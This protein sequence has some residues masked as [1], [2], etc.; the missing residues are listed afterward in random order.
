MQVK[1]ELLKE[2]VNIKECGAAERPLLIHLWNVSHH[3]KT[4]FS[5]FFWLNLQNTTKITQLDEHEMI[6]LDQQDLCESTI[7]E[8]WW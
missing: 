6:F 2:K 4:I 5:S 3:K 1:H 7:S 8:S